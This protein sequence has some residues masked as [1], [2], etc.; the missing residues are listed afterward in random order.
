MIVSERKFQVR[1]LQ[2]LPVEWNSPFWA[3]LRRPSRRGSGAALP[4][5][6]SSRLFPD[7]EDANRPSG[8]LS[9]PKGE[10]ENRGRVIRWR[11]GNERSTIRDDGSDT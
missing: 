11:I 6:V 8:I 7:S 4:D 5:S 9:M 1:L 2:Q 10:R 3:L